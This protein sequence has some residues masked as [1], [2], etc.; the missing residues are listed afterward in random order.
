MA[1]N[2]QFSKVA[3]DMSF[4]QLIWSAW[5]MSFVFAA[6]IILQRVVD[7]E[8][9]NEQS[10]LTFSYGPS[11][12]FMLVIGIISVYALLT[13]Y[14]KNGVTRKDY[15]KGAAVSSVVV[16][17]VLMTTAGII[18]A[19][20]QLIDDDIVTASFAGPDASI[21]L[22]VLVFSINILAS[23]AAGWLIGSGFY[24]FGG[25][26]GMLYIFA[27]IL[28]LS[29]LDFLWESELKEPLKFLLDISN[30]HGFSSLTSFILTAGLLAVT[31]WVIKLTT[32]RVQIK[33]K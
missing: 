12:I 15:F 3:V 11:K 10:F 14:V 30:H 27:S 21:V 28:I 33:L 25:I 17:L 9:V 18:A 19:I 5:F 24:R 29:L 4:L 22:T 26:G 23:Y 16:S 8:T 1:N 7:N 31:L 2:T 20:E 32:K 13:F 6:Y